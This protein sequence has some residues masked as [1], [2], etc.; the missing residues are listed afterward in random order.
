MKIAIPM[1]YDPRCT[2]YIRELASGKKYYISYFLPNGQRMRRPLHQQTSEAKR[3]LRIKELKLVQGQFDQ[4]D[5]LK[6]EDL[7]NTKAEQ[8]LTLSEALELYLEITKTRK[9][10][11]SHRHDELSLRKYQRIF[12]ANGVKNL[13]EVNSVE[14]Q[15]LLNQLIDQG[16]KLPTVKS[17]ATRLKKLFNWLIDEAELVQGKNPVPKRPMLVSFGSMVRDR[18][19]SNSEIKR[20]IERSR[21][22]IVSSSKSPVSEI[23]QFL[24]FTGARLGEVL[25]AEWSDFDLDKGIWHIRQKPNCPTKDN[26]GWSPKWNKSRSIVLFP[27]AKQILD[28]LPRHKSFGNVSIRDKDH[29]IIKTEQHKASFIFPKEV[30]R[31]QVVYYERVDSIKKSWATLLK[32]ANVTDLQVK[33]LRTYCNH[34]LKSKYG[35]SAKEA[36]SYLGNSEKVNE[37]H[38]TPISQEEIER[39]MKGHSMLK[40]IGITV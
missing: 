22:G 36:G 11:I 4:K 23:I 20:I 15:R 26:L 8:K 13:D 37:T 31:N 7:I 16:Q 3:L 18:L 38:Y 32:Q 33:D 29:R 10:L 21:R 24:I 27:E 17:A 25:H 14:V 2:M 40:E 34:L 9:K 6:M 1:G 30:K 28:K 19:A 12:F 5:L 39:K 35:F